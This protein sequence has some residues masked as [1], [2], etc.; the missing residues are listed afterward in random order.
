[1]PKDRGLSL[2]DIAATMKAAGI[3][4]SPVGVRT[5]SMPHGDPRAASRS[6][7]AIS[8]GPSRHRGALR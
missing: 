2:R 5:S 1:V 4:I 8:M 6:T 7:G 3:S